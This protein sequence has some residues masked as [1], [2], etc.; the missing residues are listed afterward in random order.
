MA[1]NYEDDLKKKPYKVSMKSLVKKIEKR[2][3]RETFTSKVITVIFTRRLLFS[4]LFPFLF[5]KVKESHQYFKTFCLPAQ[6]I[7]RA[8]SSSFA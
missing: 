4:H 6:A 8:F 1:S 3:W 7:L 5:G 2:L